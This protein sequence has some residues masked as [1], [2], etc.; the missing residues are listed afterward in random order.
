MKKS[1]MIIIVLAALVIGLG[2]GY[3]YGSSHTG[4]PTVNNGGR[5]FAQF[6]GN[7]GA[8]GQG[9]INNGDRT[10]ANGARGQIIALDASSLTLKLDNGGSE[11]VFYSGATPISKMVS[12][13]A[14]DL[15]VGENIMAVGQANSDGSVTASSL[16]L[17]SASSTF[18]FGGGNGGGSTNS[19]TLP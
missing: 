9:G 15:K 1:N 17:V 2:G 14:T 12:G 19:T 13:S 10:R 3:W 18:R 6:A 11:I 5:N 8:G 16:Q 4:S 7:R